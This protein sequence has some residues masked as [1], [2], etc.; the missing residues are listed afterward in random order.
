MARDLNTIASG[1]PLASELVINIALI[2]GFGLGKSSTGNSLLGKNIFKAR[3][4]GGATMAC[5]SL[6]SVT[7]GG[8]FIHVI[9]TP[10][11]IDLSASAE[12]NLEILN[13]LDMAKD[14]VH[15]VL[16]VKSVVARRS[17]EDETQ[18]NHLLLLFGNKICDYMIV[19]F[20]GGDHLEDDNMTLDDYLSYGCSDFLKVVLRMCGGRKVLFDNETKDEDKKTKQVQELMAHVA[21]VCKNNDGNPFTKEMISGGD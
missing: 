14:G 9:D 11:L 17:V 18:F 12:I 6:R 3:K 1:L 20:T 7:P 10:G 13:C 15:A 8:S 16:F 21:T 2:G 5:Q 4:G 19:I